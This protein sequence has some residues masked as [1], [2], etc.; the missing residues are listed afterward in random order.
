M[1]S[2]HC[3]QRLILTERK[4]YGT[5]LCNCCDMHLRNGDGIRTHHVILRIPQKD[6]WPESETMEMIPTNEI[7]ASRRANQWR[8]SEEVLARKS[9]QLR[10]WNNDIF[11][12]TQFFLARLQYSSLSHGENLKERRIEEETG[13]KQ[14]ELSFYQCQERKSKQKNIEIASCH[15]ALDSNYNFPW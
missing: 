12:L 3:K 13:R 8:R 4:K 9:N 11:Q 10:S 5:C 1:Q 6:D 2:L 14:D 15:P 7:G